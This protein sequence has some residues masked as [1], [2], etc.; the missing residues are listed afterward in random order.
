MTFHEVQ[1]YLNIK[2]RKTLLRYI[3]EGRLQAFKLGGTRWRILPD[4][5][6]LFIR[7]GRSGQSAR[8]N[9]SGS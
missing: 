1:N 8:D 4:D 5:L 7:N 2:S 6:E 9:F 3:R